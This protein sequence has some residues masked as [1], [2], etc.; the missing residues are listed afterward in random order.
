MLK[1]IFTCVECPLGCELSVMLDG[2]KIS[3]SGN[4]C[5][6]GRAYA[7]DEAVCPKRVVTSTVKTSSGKMLA[8]KTDGRVKKEDI[9]K[10]SFPFSIS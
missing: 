1:K 4:G 2:E 7:E 3:V 6:R 10:K 8:V 5:P 9:F